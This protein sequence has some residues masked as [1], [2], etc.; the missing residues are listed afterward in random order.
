MARPAAERLMKQVAVG[1]KARLFVCSLSGGEQ[2]VLLMT[3]ASSTR[4]HDVDVGTCAKYLLDQLV[5]GLSVGA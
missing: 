5:V 1:R 2:S 3:L 4:R